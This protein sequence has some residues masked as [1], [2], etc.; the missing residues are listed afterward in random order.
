LNGFTAGLDLPAM[1]VR[2]V[3]LDGKFDVHGEMT[4]RGF[5]CLRSDKARDNRESGFPRF[6]RR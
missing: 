4:T 5:A 3:V 2:A 1:I 6:E